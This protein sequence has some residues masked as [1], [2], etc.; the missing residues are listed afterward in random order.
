MMMWKVRYTRGRFGVQ[1][2]ERALLNGDAE[3]SRLRVFA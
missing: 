3:T 1:K 2:V